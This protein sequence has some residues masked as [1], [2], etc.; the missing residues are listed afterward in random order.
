[1]S[2][3]IVENYPSL[4]RTRT[5]PLASKTR[6]IAMTQEERDAKIAEFELVLPSL[7]KIQEQLLPPQ[8]EG[9]VNIYYF[10]GRLNPPHL[11]HIETLSQ[12]I[13]RA[14]SENVDNPNYKIIILLGSGPKNG[15]PLDNPLS[16]ETKKD[17]IT[18]KLKQLF[19]N[20]PPNF[21]FDQNVEILEMQRAPD[22]ITQITLPL[23]LVSN[24]IE[25][26]NMYR[27]SGAKDGDDEK[28]NWIETTIKKILK[29]YSNILSTEVVPVIPVTN[30]E[31][32]EAM[33][34]TEVR[35]SILKGFLDGNIHKYF[36]RFEDF[37]GDEFSDKI[38][39]EIAGVAE[40]V[41]AR[42]P[43]AVAEYISKKGGSKKSKHRRPIIKQRK[44][45][46]RKQTKR[47]KTKRRKCKRLTKRR[48]HY[49]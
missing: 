20:N 47:R 30:E 42:N 38:A 3:P 29:D 23:V 25:E 13:Q 22:Q 39:K 33:S 46:R 4:S 18:Y 16:F 11:G 44:S 8:E 19:P 40:K 5:L 24:L 21:I 34:A 48:R 10:I 43:G 9:I 37:Y 45:K 41:N 49:R 36:R 28:L 1:M 31:K 2:L 12:L 6:K 15:N 14:I 32:D 35:L 17:F 7:L 26:I 27:F